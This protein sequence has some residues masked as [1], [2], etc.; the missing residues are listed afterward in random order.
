ML[1][2]KYF[3]I[4]YS[5]CTFI[6]AVS[7]N[8][9]SVATTPWHTYFVQY[10]MNSWYQ[11]MSRL[12][13]VGSQRGGLWKWYYRFKEYFAVVYSWYTCSW[14]WCSPWMEL[15]YRCDSSLSYHFFDHDGWGPANENMRGIAWMKTWICHNIYWI[16][17]R[18][19]ADDEAILWMID[20]CLR[21]Y[22]AEGQER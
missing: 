20:S 9:M 3:Y 8:K 7:E 11:L 19:P 6:G 15:T 14:Y 12:G 16:I 17:Y 13:K 22:M 2:E 21:I 5:Y 4:A 1:S 10:E 18:I